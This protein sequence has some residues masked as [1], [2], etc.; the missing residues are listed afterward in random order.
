MRCSFRVRGSFL[1][2]E[3]ENVVPSSFSEEL[4]EVD[5]DAKYLKVEDEEEKDEEVEEEL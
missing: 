5:G 3:R 4:L 1:V 2:G